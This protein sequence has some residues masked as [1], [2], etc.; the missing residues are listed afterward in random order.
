M[1]IKDHFVEFIYKRRLGNKVKHINKCLYLD[2]MD[3]KSGKITCNDNLPPLSDEFYRVVM[4]GDT[5]DRHTCLD[6]LPESDIFVHCGDIFMTS[7]FFSNECMMR[8]LIGFNEWLGNS[9][10]SKHKIVIAGNHDSHM[11]QMGPKGVQMIL[12]N[13]TYLHNNSAVIDNMFHIWATPKSKGTSLNRAF[14]TH[15][16]AKYTDKCVQYFKKIEKNATGTMVNNQRERFALNVTGTSEVVT[17]ESKELKLCKEASNS[18]FTTITATGTTSNEIKNSAICL[19]VHMLVTHGE[20]SDIVHKITPEFLHVWGHA[21]NSYG[22]YKQGDM[23]KGHISAAPISICCPIMDFMYRPHSLPV[24]VD[25]KKSRVQDANLDYQGRIIQKEMSRSFG[26]SALVA[27]HKEDSGVYSN[28]SSLSST[29]DYD[30]RKIAKK[31]SNSLF[32][33]FFDSISESWVGVKYKNSSKKITKYK[34]DLK[35]DIDKSTARSTSSQ[36]IPLS[37]KDE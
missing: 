1:E 7:R 16:F 31:E 6:S 5:H 8:K 12:T 22:V 11:E 4:V 13:G 34:N 15:G 24:V 27:V 30:H 10:K 26:K 37:Q 36:V 28:H 18:D 9:V 3:D 2:S 35:V 21:H 17:H 20:C 32:R 29:G 19:P 25:I 23:I 33:A 14:Q